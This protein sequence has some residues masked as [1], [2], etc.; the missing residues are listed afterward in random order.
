MTQ[1]TN[2]LSQAL[3]IHTVSVFDPAPSLSFSPTCQ[4]FGLRLFDFF[5]M[6]DLNSL[7]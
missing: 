7:F 4:V 2:F 1:L 3:N 5:V 6:N